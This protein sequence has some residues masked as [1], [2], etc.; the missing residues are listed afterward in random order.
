MTENL[1]IW[2]LA[3]V[4]IVL[5]TF[6]VTTLLCSCSVNLTCIQSE[7]FAAH[8]IDD[9]DSPALDLPVIGAL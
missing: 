7:G 2:T 4:E 6:I 5:F 1:K 8:Q 3:S 9:K